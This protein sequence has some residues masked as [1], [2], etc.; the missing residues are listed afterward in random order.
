MCQ[1]VAPDLHQVLLAVDA[2]HVVAEPH[3]RLGHGAAEAAQAD[4]DHAVARRKGELFCKNP[5]QQLD[6]AFKNV[7]ERAQRILP[8]PNRVVDRIRA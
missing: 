7:R 6:A 2:H 5:T 4:D 1:S 8:A 3:Q